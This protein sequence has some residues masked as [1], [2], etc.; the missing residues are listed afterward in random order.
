MVAAHDGKLLLLEEKARPPHER[1]V[2]EHPQVVLRHVVGPETDM[3]AAQMTAKL[4]PRPAS[5]PV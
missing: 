2:A 4:E 5:R 3:F 1:T